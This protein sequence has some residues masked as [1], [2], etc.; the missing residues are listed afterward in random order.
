MFNWFKNKFS[1][2][3]ENDENKIEEVIE[4]STKKV[5]EAEI[6]EPI[7]QKKTE[8]HE[9]KNEPTFEKKV[10]T[11]EEAFKNETIKTEVPEKKE[12]PVVKEVV[13]E[14]KHV[15]PAPKI[16]T[17]EEIKEEPKQEVVQ[18]KYEE[19]KKELIHAAV[20]KELENTNDEEELKDTKESIFK[21]FIKGVN[22]TRKNFSYQINSVFTENDIDDDFYEELEEVMVMGDIGASTTM[23]IIDILKE[24]II[25]KGIHKTSE[26]K[27]L[28][29]EIILEVMNEH[30][31]DNYLH[32]EPSPA[33]LMLVGVNGVGKTT[34][35]GK[36]AY[37]FKQEGKSVAIIA[38]DTFRAAAI[39]Q[40]E[41]WGERAGV[42]IISQKE[43]SDPAAVV[44][45]GLDY[46]IK[47][48][49]DITIIDTAGRLHN[50]VNLMNEL[51]KVKRII[52]KKMPN[53]TMEVILALDATTGQNALLQ[54]K[55]FKEAAEITGVSLN[56]LD[57][58][59][60]GGVII[61][62]QYEEKIPVKIVGVGESI[63]DL[64]PFEPELFVNA[65]FE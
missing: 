41:V 18:E 61:P 7:F 6:S 22:K 32:L 46:S 29:K 47:N 56:K 57:G 62:I 17:H 55:E 63:Y 42:K 49:I 1:K 3:K 38:A 14:E 13:T 11:H 34:T 26:A 31:E 5:D 48:N 8:S 23:T 28:L 21:R 16:E 27:E 44:F 51:N 40:L 54:V 12:E 45:D 60:K 59:A 58:T 43:G 4:E 24:R 64:Q 25:D 2:K 39:E 53:A 19:P 52:D 36:L 35:C 65:I 37:Q 10:E 15:E 50:K 33:I 30:I 9:I 20:K